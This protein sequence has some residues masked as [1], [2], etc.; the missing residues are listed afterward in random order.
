MMN[1]VG[2]KEGFV[3]SFG[4]SMIIRGELRYA[5]A[6]QVGGMP[7]NSYYEK[8]NYIF[9]TFVHQLLSSELCTLSVI[10]TGD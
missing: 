1:G 6:G 8:H 9:C 3:L 7:I 10:E 5:F 4:E 2:D